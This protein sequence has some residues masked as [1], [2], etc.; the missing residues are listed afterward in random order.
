MMEAEAWGLAHIMS[1][2]LFG[3]FDPL[4]SPNNSYYEYYVRGD[5]HMT[6]TLRGEGG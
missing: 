2:K 5:V 4:F 3:L 6:S 1:A